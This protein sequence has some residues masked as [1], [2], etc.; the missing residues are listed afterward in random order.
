MCTNK[1]VKLFLCTQSLGLLH[2]SETRGTSK[3]AHLEKETPKPEVLPDI[4]VFFATHK[5][6]SKVAAAREKK[7]HWFWNP[8]PCGSG[9]SGNLIHDGTSEHS[10]PASVKKTPKALNTSQWHY[11]LYNFA[12]PCTKAG[13]V[14]SHSTLRG[15]FCAPLIAAKSVFR[16]TTLEFSIDRLWEVWCWLKAHHSLPSRKNNNSSQ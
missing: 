15:S 7:I 13:F 4:F 2:S 1:P 10:F 16:V 3:H 6:L 14:V 12:A 11:F 8:L 9:G 5:T